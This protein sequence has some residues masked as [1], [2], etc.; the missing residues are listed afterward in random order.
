[1]ARAIYFILTP[2][3]GLVISAETVNPVENYYLLEIE[4]GRHKQEWAIWFLSFGWLIV[5]PE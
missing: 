2:S 4:T 1:M 3:Q 5:S